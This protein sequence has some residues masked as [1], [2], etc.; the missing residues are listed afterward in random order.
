MDTQLVFNYTGLIVTVSSLL[1][2]CTNAF[3][4]TAPG[5]AKT[6]LEVDGKRERNNGLATFQCSQQIKRLIASAFA[7]WTAFV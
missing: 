4:P 7:Q 5:Y 1:Y 2:V 3:Q 6:E